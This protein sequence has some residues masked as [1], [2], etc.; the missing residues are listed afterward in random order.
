MSSD[1]RNPILDIMELSWIFFRLWKSFGII[2]KLRNF[3]EISGIVYKYIFRGVCAVC[4]RASTG[5]SEYGPK[6]GCF[7]S[8]V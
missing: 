4:T 1:P 2:L 8:T 6:I 5:K 3:Y 7:T